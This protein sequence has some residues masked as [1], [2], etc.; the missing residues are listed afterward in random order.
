MN[1]KYDFKCNKTLEGLWFD[2]WHK[3]SHVWKHKSLQWHHT[4]CNWIS[5]HG[6]ESL[7]SISRSGNQI[8]EFG[9][10]DKYNKNKQVVA[11]EHLKRASLFINRSFK[12]LW[13]KYLC[14]EWLGWYIFEM[15]E[16]EGG[17]EIIQQDAFTQSSLL[18]CYNIYIYIYIYSMLL[19]SHMSQ[20]HNFPRNQI[21][22]VHLKRF[23][24]RS[25]HFCGG[26]DCVW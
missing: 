18:E 23:A 9:S 1:V 5:L 13:I 8:K 3:L 2:D 11:Y 17:L 10:F 24:T 6:I 26:V 15:W 14:W 20:Y 7:K 12:V 4:Q 16:H 19:T 21:L 22:W 25:N